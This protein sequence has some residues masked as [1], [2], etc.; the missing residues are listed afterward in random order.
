MAEAEAEIR[1]LV[2][3]RAEAVRSKDAGR[4][5]A[6]LADDVVAFELPPPLALGPE[7]LRDQAALEAWF[8][9]WEG[10]LEVEIRDLDV[11]VFGGVGYCHSLNRLGGTRSDGRRVSFW[12][13]STL[14][15]RRIGEQWKIAHAHSSVPFYMDGSF[16]AALDLR[17]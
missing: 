16:R 13:R 5:I 1:A 15:L 2:E 3:E 6:T 11:A 9:G 12:M 14:G 4:A 8:A 10:P 7:Q 17:P